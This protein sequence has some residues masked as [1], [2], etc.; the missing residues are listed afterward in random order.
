MIE[1]FGACQSDRRSD[2][3][4]INMNIFDDDSILI[5]GI[6]YTNL[7]GAFTDLY[8]IKYNEDTPI[9]FELFPLA[10]QL[11]D[12]HYDK[13]FL[14][15]K[16]NKTEYYDPFRGLVV[17]YKERKNV[18]YLIDVIHNFYSNIT[19]GIKR[20]P[21]VPSEGPRM[22]TKLLFRLWAQSPC[23]QTKS[24]P[25]ASYSTNNLFVHPALL[26]HIPS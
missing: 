6:Y 8:R 1:L 20:Y 18:N 5:E 7:N 4:G 11:V 9:L 17:K 26:N 3:G 19:C 16:F 14:I 15:Q 24:L 12:K 22:L 21:P 13:E 2:V 10:D 23:R 25:T